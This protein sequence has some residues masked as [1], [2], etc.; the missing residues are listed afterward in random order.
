MISVHM[1]RA[2]SASTARMMR[3]RTRNVQ[4]ARHDLV[5]VRFLGRAQDAVDRREQFRQRERERGLGRRWRLRQIGARKLVSPLFTASL[6]DVYDFAHLLVL[7]QPPHELGPRILP[8]LLVAPRQQ[9][10][11]FDAQQARRHF[12]VLGCLVERQ[13]CECARRTVR[14]SVRSEYR[15]CRPALRE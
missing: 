11:R 8:Q 12:Q 3:D 1:I 5:H 2:L 14:R 13:A 6:E 9:H 4:R 15:R 10:L 7:E